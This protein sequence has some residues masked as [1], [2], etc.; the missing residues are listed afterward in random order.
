MLE[1][2]HFFGFI[3]GPGCLNECIWS[4]DALCP[5]CKLVNLKNCICC[6]IFAVEMPGSVVEV[7]LCVRM[8]LREKAVELYV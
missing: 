8:F 5:F 3:Y 4:S 1:S 2:E 7:L 6:Q